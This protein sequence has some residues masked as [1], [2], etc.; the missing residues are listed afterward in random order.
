MSSSQQTLFTRPPTPNALPDEPAEYFRPADPEP[1]ALQNDISSLDEDQPA[2][3]FRPSY[4]EPGAPEN[5]ISSLDEDEPAEYFRPTVPPLPNQ[6]PSL[7]QD[8]P[9]EYFRPTDAEPGA[10]EN[11]LLFRDTSLQLDGQTDMSD[12]FNF[13]YLATHS[14]EENL[15]LECLLQPLDMDVDIDMGYEEGGEGGQEE[16]IEAR[17]VA[18]LTDVSPAPPP[19]DG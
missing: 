11:D 2:E 6:I 15:G 9:E 13:N 16:D 19:L 4:P 1:G 5:D 14:T 12:L 7:D 18:A 3:Y 17:L 10:L 8:Q